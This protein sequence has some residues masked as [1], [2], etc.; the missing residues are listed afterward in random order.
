MKDDPYTYGETD[1]LINHLNI[2]DFDELQLKEREITSLRTE[3]LAE[4]PPKKTFDLSHLQQI[5]GHLFQ[6]LY[7]FA[8]QIRTVSFSKNGHN[9][10]PHQNIEKMAAKMTEHLRS[11]QLT[12]PRA[13]LSNRDFIRS[14]AETLYL[15]NQMHPFR[16]GNGRT[17]RI[18]LNHIAEQSVRSFDWTKVSET[19]NLEC[20]VTAGS[21]GPIAFEKTLSH[22]AVHP[23]SDFQRA[24]RRTANAAS[25][26]TQRTQNHQPER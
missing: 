9:F 20:S 2:R 10:T 17:Q 11:S 8:G 15:I 21:K 4:N 23:E 3:Q 19:Q 26:L 14:S 5:H 22:A 18:F 25:R 13:D 1:V 24:A 16:E 12:D 7:P 6:D